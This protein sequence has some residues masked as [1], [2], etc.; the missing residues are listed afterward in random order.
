MKVKQWNSEHPQFSPFCSVMRSK[1]GNFS[2]FVKEIPKQSHCLRV[3]NNIWNLKWR[4]HQNQ[5]WK[6]NKLRIR[7]WVFDFD[8]KSQLQRVN[9]S[10]GVF[11][12]FSDDCSYFRLG[13][14]SKSFEEIALSQ[15]IYMSLNFHKNFKFYKFS[16]SR[17]AL[18]MSQHQNT[19]Y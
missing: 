3:L 9:S 5:K 14:Q 18:T 17:F 8:N 13:V 6:S 7:W 19:S 12:K 1:T 16:M 4:I 11:K 2:C 10:I 15:V